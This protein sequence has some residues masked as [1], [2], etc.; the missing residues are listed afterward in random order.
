MLEIKTVKKG[1]ELVSVIFNGFEKLHDG[2]NYWNRHSPVLFPIVG[3]LK[4]GKT[5]INGKIYEMGQHGFARDME[6][7]EIE[8][9]SYVLKSNEKTLEKF[10]F[11]FELYVS[12]EVKKDELIT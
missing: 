4:D 12:Y 7:E 9:N 11:R 3:K 10:P 1:A 5:Q 6:F 2:K 8:E